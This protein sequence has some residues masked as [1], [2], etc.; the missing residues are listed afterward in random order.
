MSKLRRARLK[1]RLDPVAFDSIATE[2]DE[3]LERR[4]RKAKRLTDVASP[5]VNLNP[6]LMLALA[7]AYNIASPFEAAEY[8]QLSKML[9]GDSTAFGRYVEDKILPVF[10][11][12]PVAEKKR[13]PKLY[14][15][16]DAEVSVEGK[17]YLMTLKAGPW[18]M[19]QSHANEMVNRF[20]EIHDKTGDDIVIGIF[21]GS[22]SRLNNKPRLV[23]VNTGDYVT[24]LVGKDFW[25]FVTGVKDAHQEIFRAI[26]E[27]QSR[28]AARHGGE[29]FYEQMIEA[30]LALSRSIR[31]A[32]GLGA[33]DIDMWEQLFE[34]AF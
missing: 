14:S 31:E 25:E 26:R 2:T 34:G 7:P 16:I 1:Q 11:V 5:D 18:T 27:A 29:T 10:G 28:F 17:R 23:E 24:T 4:L 20:P 33:E 32:F 9:H 15:P 6:F 22:R 13:S 30:R 12:R 19:N 21:Y 8:V 3:L